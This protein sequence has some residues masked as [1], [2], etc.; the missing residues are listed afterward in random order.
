MNE[1]EE[2][3]SSAIGGQASKNE[4]MPESVASTRSESSTKPRS[5]GIIGFRRR[6]RA[7]TKSTGKRL[8]ESGA[9]GLRITAVGG[10]E[11]APKD[12]S[13]PCLQGSLER[14]K[15]ELDL[16]EK[17]LQPATRKEAAAMFGRLAVQF[18]NPDRPEEHWTL[19]AEDYINEL[20]IFPPDIL[21]QGRREALRR[22]TFMP[23]ISE[24]LGILEPMRNERQ[25]RRRELKEA[26]KP[27]PRKEQ[28]WK[29][30]T[31]EEKAP[32]Q[33]AID[34]AFKRIPRGMSEDE[35]QERLASDKV[36]FVNGMRKAGMI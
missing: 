15:T 33:T 11:I 16:V 2:P 13:A 6:G 26:L 7:P 21:E 22:C 3:G 1:N 34:G 31:D 36:E 17:A 9:E 4:T 29:P 5:S 12:A 32:I 20:C 35:A 28:D 14:R 24:L 8:G 18:P 25:N 30:P 23:R 27:K 19:I 10:Q